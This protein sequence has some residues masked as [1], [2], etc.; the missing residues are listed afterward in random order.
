MSPVRL[1]ALAAALVLFVSACRG[2]DDPQAE[3]AARS[4]SSTTTVEATSAEAPNP[5]D[6]DDSAADEPA[7]TPEHGTAAEASPPQGSTPAGVAA[8][9]VP[10]REEPRL[11]LELS[12]ELT[13]RCV[14][15][16]GTQKIT[17]MA[18]PRSAVGYSAVYADGTTGWSPD[19][20]GGANHG[21]TNAS[22]KWSDVWV[23]AADAPEGQVLVDV[24]GAGQDG[25]VGRTQVT[26]EVADLTGTCG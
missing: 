4:A 19:H 7:S 16:G 1:L 15:P 13:S 12:A 2:G 17:I 26:F 18:P 21:H 24:G 5:G 10:D 23:V 11:D 20:Y 14:R 8:G 25:S 22:G 3:A 6:A 9:S